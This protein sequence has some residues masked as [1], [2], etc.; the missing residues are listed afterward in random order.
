M[1]TPENRGAE[2]SA[3]SRIETIEDQLRNGSDPVHLQERLV[4]VFLQ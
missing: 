2:P 3:R 4:E 1:S